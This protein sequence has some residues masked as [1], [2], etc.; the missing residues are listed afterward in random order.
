MNTMGL[1]NLGERV[2]HLKVYSVDEGFCGCRGVELVIPDEAFRGV[3]ALIAGNSHRIQ[4]M[5][6]RQPVKNIWVVGSGTGKRLNLLGINTALDLART[7]PTFISK[8][9]SVVLKRTVHELNG[10]SCIEM[11]NAPRLKSR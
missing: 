9:L 1:A 11:E 7:F 5:L 10:E 6:S 2:P 3:L 4:M 8:N